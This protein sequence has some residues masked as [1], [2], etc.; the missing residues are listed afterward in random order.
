MV[1]VVGDGRMVREGEVGGCAIVEKAVWSKHVLWDFKL[2]SVGKEMVK[3]H[4]WLRDTLLRHLRDS[5]TR[6]DHLLSL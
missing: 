2:V 4:R 6:R 5:L 3:T 1:N